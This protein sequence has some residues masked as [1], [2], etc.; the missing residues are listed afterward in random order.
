[1]R[2][3]FPD[4]YIKVYRISIMERIFIIAASEDITCSHLTS[5][6]KAKMECYDWMEM[7]GRF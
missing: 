4:I 1:M 5:S 7:N 6:F 2:C 3:F